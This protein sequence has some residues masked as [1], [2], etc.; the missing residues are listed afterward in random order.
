MTWDD[1]SSSSGKKGSSSKKNSLKSVLS[2][3]HTFEYIYD[4]GSTTELRLRVGDPIRIENTAEAVAVLGMNTPPTRTC[5][6]CGKPAICHYTENDD[7]T[8][9]CKECSE[10]PDL[11]ECYL[12]PITNS[13]RTGICAY[14]GGWYDEEGDE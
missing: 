12:L 9:L 13:P 10:D 14:E 1:E 4:Y 5:S 3:G 11:D 2:P 6:E 8:V 7:D